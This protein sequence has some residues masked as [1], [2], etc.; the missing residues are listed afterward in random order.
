MRFAS[1]LTPAWEP[2]GAEFGEQ[3]LAAL[4]MEIVTINAWNRICV[5]TRM[6]P[7][8]YKG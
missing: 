2:A 4:V 8:S 5:T 7:E 6:V 1:P 3:L